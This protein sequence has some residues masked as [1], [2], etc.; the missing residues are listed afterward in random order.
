MS[1][2]DIN[3]NF[4][5]FFDKKWEVW[6]QNWGDYGEDLVKKMSKQM[7]DIMSHDGDLWDRMLDQVTTAHWIDRAI[8]KYLIG[9]TQELNN[10]IVAMI[11]RIHPEFRYITIVYNTK[12]QGGDKIIPNVEIR[13][14]SEWFGRDKNLDNPWHQ[15]HATICL[16]ISH[17][18]CRYPGWQ[19]SVK[20]PIP[21]PTK[22][23]ILPQY[24]RW[25]K[26]RVY[27]KA[28]LNDTFQPY[29]IF[30]EG[31]SMVRNF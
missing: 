23:S 11:R 17:K 12:V 7:L 31:E 29:V 5:L 2:L 25:R 18:V 4:D 20:D 13:M 27:G 8:P 1:V 10:K 19:T 15:R 9:M 6:P 3:E 21:T 30:P 16:H 26:R 24:H 14:D 28:R 22:T